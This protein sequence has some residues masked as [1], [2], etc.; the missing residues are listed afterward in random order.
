MTRRAAADY[1]AVEAVGDVGSGAM[2]AG[3]VLAMAVAVLLALAP[4]AD[5]GTG[6]GRIRT[7]LTKPDQASAATAVMARD[8]LTAPAGWTGGPQKP[9]LKPP[10]PCSGFRPRQSDLVRTG[11]AQSIFSSAQGISFDSE[12]Q[13]VQTA[14]MLQLDWRRTVLAPQVPVCLRARMLREIS[15]SKRTFVAFGRLAFPKVTPRTVAYRVIYDDRASA[16]KVRRFTDLVFVGMSRTELFV[17]TTAPLS[18]ASYVA[19]AEERL[20]RRLVARIGA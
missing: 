13:V 15:A 2:R 19:P 10:S 4:V 9:D 7:K 3:R 5:A 14:R 1:P 12:A 11:V 6:D 16:G 8:D 18:Q 17:G 20:V